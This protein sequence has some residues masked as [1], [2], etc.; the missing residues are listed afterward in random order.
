MPEVGK[1]CLNGRTACHRIDDLQASSS[2]SAFQI[3]YRGSED[4]MHAGRPSRDLH[5]NK[6]RLRRGKGRPD[7]CDVVKYM[8]QAETF[9]CVKHEASIRTSVHSQLSLS[10]G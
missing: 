2:R 4:G 10:D 7:N 1:T 8:T 5:F 6:S 9:A 3:K